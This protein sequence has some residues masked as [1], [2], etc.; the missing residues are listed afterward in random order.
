MRNEAAYCLDNAGWACNEV[1]RHYVEGRLIAADMDRALSYFSR[2]CETRFQAGCVNLLDPE[3]PSRADPRTIDLRLL[4]REGGPNLL[5]MPEPDL[6][7]RACR[8]GWSFACQ[9]QSAA[10]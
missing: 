3:T 1:G 2:A 4:L 10:R 5:D 8:H 9:R 6:Y 7:A